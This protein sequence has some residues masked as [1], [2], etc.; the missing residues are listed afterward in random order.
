MALVSGAHQPGGRVLSP[1]AGRHH[2]SAADPASDQPRQPVLEAALSGPSPPPGRRPEGRLVHQG[3]VGPLH[4]RP[5]RRR[6]RLPEGGAKGGLPGAALGGTAQ[7][8][9][10]PEQ[11]GDGGGR[12]HRLPR[13]RPP[14]RPVEGGAGRP[15]QVE[16]S[17]QRPRPLSRRRPGEELHHH[18]S[19]RRVREEPV[20]V[21]RVLPVAVG[22]QAPHIPPLRPPDRQ[23]GADLLAGVSGVHLVDHVLKGGQTAVGPLGIEAVVDGDV[24]HMPGGEVHLR[25]LPG[26][27]VVPAQAAQIL[28]EDQVHPPGLHILQKPPEPRPLKAGARKAVV[29]VL[30]RHL[31]AMVGGVGPEKGPLAPDAHALPAPGVVPGQPQIEGRPEGAHRPR[32]YRRHAA[33]VSA[34]TRPCSPEPCTISRNRVFSR[35]PMANTSPPPYVPGP[36]TLPLIDFSH[37]EIV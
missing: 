17:G 6:Q 15:P 11:L 13:P 25:Q 32:R 29:H 12:P 4:H 9:G 22:G 26:A 20:P 31:P 2:G 23:G 34:W 10:V 28:G 35:F 5:V 3:G 8:G 19:R 21:R 27:D 16:H 33:S 37:R 30:P 24:A 7:I 14:S 36:S 18:R 1:G